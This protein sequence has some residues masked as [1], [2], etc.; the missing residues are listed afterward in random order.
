MGTDEANR[1]AEIQFQKELDAIKGVSISDCGTRIELRCGDM[2]VATTASSVPQN[3][4]E[5]ICLLKEVISILEAPAE[6]DPEFF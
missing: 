5:L 6:K 3:E 4:E 1:Q 2:R